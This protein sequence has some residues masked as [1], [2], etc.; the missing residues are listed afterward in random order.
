M[1]AS[2]VTL[3]K[4]VLRSG[5]NWELL[6]SDDLLSTSIF[7]VGIDA[8]DVLELGVDA[9][10]TQPLLQCKSS[11]DL[12]LQR[13]NNTGGHGRIQKLSTEM[14]RHRMGDVTVHHGTL[15]TYDLAAAV[16]KRPRGCGFMVYWSLTSLCCKFGINGKPSDWIQKG[17]TAWRNA[18]A[19]VLG[20]HQ[21][22]IIFSTQ[23]SSATDKLQ[24]HERC[25]PWPAVATSGLLPLLTKFAFFD[26]SQGGFGEDQ[27]KRR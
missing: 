21:G 16:F 22:Q 26:R 18:C 19:G 17:I 13:L 20:S 5:Y 23:P 6:K 3:E 2:L 1:L 4:V 15:S 8:E 12:Y 27:K 14:V 9:V 25:L 10:L 7:G 24:W 11:E